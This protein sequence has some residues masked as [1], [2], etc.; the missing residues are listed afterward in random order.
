MTKNEELLE[1]LLP[2]LRAEITGV[3]QALASIQSPEE[4]QS[5]LEMGKVLLRSVEEC[6]RGLATYSQRL[7]EARRNPMP[8]L[9]LDDLGKQ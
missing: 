8:L 3:V 5:T 2:R 1:F 7:A 6:L 4:H 9:H